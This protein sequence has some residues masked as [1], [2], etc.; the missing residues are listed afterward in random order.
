MRLTHGDYSQEKIYDDDPASVAAGFEEAGAKFLHVVDLDGAKQ[1]AP[2]NLPALR[3]ILE[4]IGIPVEFGGGIR[5]LAAA[6]EVLDMGVERV[7]VGTKLV[8]DR[9]LAAEMFREFGS[10]VV[11]GID[12]KNGKVAVAGWIEESAI[13][14]FQ[15][16]E[17]LEKDGAKRF[18]VTDIATDGAL[19]GPNLEF[20]AGFL[21]RLYSPVIASGGVSNL[22]DIKALQRLQN[23]A[24]EG[25]IVGKAI[26]ENRLDL[27]EALAT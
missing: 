3:A 5:S 8:Q 21:D 16:A 15:L 11:A 27:R 22:D 9:N 19:Q 12:A 14:A 6:R 25:V 4:E 7:I 17:E 13:D 24:L 18:I 2:A 1:G 20:L 26:Y 10:H 23:G